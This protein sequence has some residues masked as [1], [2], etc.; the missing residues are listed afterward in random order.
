[1]REIPILADNYYHV[2][3]RGNLKQLLFHD[4]ADHARFLFLLLHLQSPVVLSQ[5]CR[6]IKKY[7]KSGKF[8]VSEDYI[9]QIKQE[10][11][12]EIINFCIMPNHFHITVR[13]LTEDGISKYMHRVS[14]AYAK[15]FNARYE[16]T[17]HVF[18]G[19]YKARLVLDDRQLT[20]LSAYIHRNPHE[21][22]VWEGRSEEYPW[23]S[24]QDYQINRWDGLLQPRVITE[25][26]RSFQDY[27]HFVVNSGAKE[28]W[29][30]E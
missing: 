11:F 25:T 20:Y 14:S 30:N 18:Q 27:H 21:I 16:K 22:K 3:N 23:S 7:L 28:N 29:I 2:Y 15:Y 9:K 1:M 12:V 4:K 5:T 26:F 17:G 8:D 13:S 19:T 6:Y 24:Y 10:K